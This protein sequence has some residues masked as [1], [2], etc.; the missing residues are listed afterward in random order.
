MIYRL[1]TFFIIIFLF[2]GCKNQQA[3]NEYIPKYSNNPFPEV[4][5][6][7]I[8]GI[9][10]GENPNLTY[11]I[12][13]PLIEYINKR[14]KTV[15]LRIE[16][17]KNYDSFNKK[18]YSNHFD[19]A[20]ANPY[21]ILE[22]NEENYHVFAKMG[23][24]E[25]FRGLIIVRKDSSIHT[26]ND[27]KGKTISYPAPSA[28][29][30][31]MM[32]QLF[33]QEHSLNV[34]KDIHNLYVGSQESA[35]LNVYLK[36]SDAAGTWPP[37]WKNFIIEHPNIAKELMIKWQTP[38]LVNN[39]IIARNDLPSSVIHEIREI[40]LNMD[41]NKEGQKA[42]ARLYINKFEY[43]DLQTYEPAKSF[44]KKFNTEINTFGDHN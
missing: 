38:S 21:T 43:A 17:S 20:L 15:K 16:T 44:L 19:L 9:Y 23:N 28:L 24:D 42:L 30:A 39:G 33:L 6:V 22:S 2:Q 7:Y 37:S 14:L 11:E 13:T 40:L 31:A 26:I 3:E 27:L 29:A 25:I 18:I 34:T 35:I 12:Y 10:A 5:K 36:K 32:T 1:L 4:E 8:L 41:K